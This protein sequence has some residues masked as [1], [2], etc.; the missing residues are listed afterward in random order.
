MSNS[1]L[2]EFFQFQAYVTTK[3]IGCMSSFLKVSECESGWS[4]VR[5]NTY[6]KLTFRTTENY[7]EYSSVKINTSRSNTI[8]FNIVYL[9]IDSDSF[10]KRTQGHDIRR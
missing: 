5:R 7:L 4:T 10:E 1:V 9:M 6:L 3:K 2:N 8:T